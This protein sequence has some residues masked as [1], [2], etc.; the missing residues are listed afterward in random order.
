[1][2]ALAL[3]VLLAA[4]PSF[5]QGSVWVVDETGAG[6]FLDIQPAV[7]AASSGDVVLVRSGSY[8]GFLLTTG[9]TVTADASASVVLDS[10][11][12]VKG[13]PE[14]ETAILRGLTTEDST[15]PWDVNTTPGLRVVASAGTVWIEDMDVEGGTLVPAV[16]IRDSER[17]V[18]L[19]SKIDGFDGHG[20]Y[21]GYSR[22]L[23]GSGLLSVQSNLHAYECNITGGDGAWPGVVGG[24]DTKPSEGETGA[25]VDG[26]FAFFGNC[27]I[28]GGEGGDGSEGDECWYAEHGG[29]GLHALNAASV[30]SSQSTVFAGGRGG[31]NGCEGGDG[32]P[33]EDIG[34]GSVVALGGTATTMRVPL[35]LQAGT[36]A[37]LYFTGPPGAALSLGL[38]KGPNSLFSSANQGALLL[39][40]SVKVIYL[41]SLHYHWGHLYVDLPIPSLPAGYPSLTM[42]AQ[43]A[44]LD[45]RVILGPAAAATILR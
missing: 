4:A 3:I 20:P 37:T 31:G 28:N 6:D 19:G 34:A 36:T 21:L 42:F 24:S 45:G 15:L 41:G 18:L 2:R 14:R 30:Y 35:P 10:T 23:A 16:E 25:T 13:L 9:L 33:G 43:A 44:F 39:N 22:T 1:M 7:D 38:S 5:A 29:D 26:G 27:T 8:R 11:I 32:R 12:T 40:L 17:V